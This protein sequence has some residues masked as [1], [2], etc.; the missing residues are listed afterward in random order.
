MS[1]ITTR[2]V[3]G[4]L[5]KHSTDKDL[6]ENYYVT[7]QAIGSNRRALDTI[8]Y[9]VYEVLDSVVESGSTDNL[10]KITG[11]GARIG[12]VLRIETSANNINEFEVFI[13]HIVDANNFELAAVLSASLTAGDTIKIMRPIVPKLSSD[14]V[15]LASIASSPIQFLKNGS[16]V[17]VNEDTGTP[18]NN[19][20]LPVKL[21]DIT[22]DVNITAGDINVQNTDMGANF[23][24][25]RIG[26]GS[27]SYAPIGQDDNA[28]SLGVA[29]STE[30]EQLL[31]DIEL[32]T[33]TALVTLGLAAD[34][35]AGTDTDNTGFISLFKRNLQRITS[36]IALFP[37]S[38]GQKNKAGSLSVTLASD[39]DALAVTGPL[40]DTQ[41][42]ATAV[43][44]S[45]PLTDT[46]L[47][48]TA[49]PVSGPLTDTQL[50]AAAVPVSASSLPLPT[51]AATETTLGSVD[52]NIGALAD[53]AVSNPASNASVIAA[54]KGLLTLLTLTNTKLDTLD[55]NTSSELDSHSTQTVTSGSAVTFTAPASARF[56]V[57]QNSLAS[58]GA[59]RF[60]KSSSTPTASDGFYLGVG[61]S[62]ALLPAGSL[63]V[64]ATT[65]SEDADISVLW[66]V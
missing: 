15:T 27:G 13:D 6:R 35:A 38:I 65:A 7:G 31:T 42:R 10:V 20:P 62:T 55:T 50:R 1:G 12:D 19:I 53:A 24:S 14:G 51:G 48:A 34:A 23:D 63:K 8:A 49:V 46:Q 61:Q 21:V 47:R 66:F 5:Q 16:T 45:G 40:T 25:M 56:M 2:P 43:P 37:S 17:T 41:L 60:V 64:I 3:Y 28:A 18:T 39:N 52:T 57:I 36:L 26:D 44:V 9:G 22:G 32:N 33:N 29:L 30:Q 54:L 11:H 59:A 4:K 58:S